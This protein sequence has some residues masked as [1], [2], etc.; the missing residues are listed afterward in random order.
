LNSSKKLDW[1]DGSHEL[2]ALNEGET[3]FLANSNKGSG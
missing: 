3:S 1:V 2:K